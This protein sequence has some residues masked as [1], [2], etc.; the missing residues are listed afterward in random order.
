MLHLLRRPYPPSI[1]QQLS[2]FRG[3]GEDSA[4]GLTTTQSHAHAWLRSQQRSVILPTVSV[5]PRP[6]FVH[7]PSSQALQC[8][9]GRWI[10]A[11][12]PRGGRGA[13]EETRGQGP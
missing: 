13:G 11:G 2:A 3:C 4:C 6:L 7:L 8:W 9:A 10:R 5:T 12:R 1:Q